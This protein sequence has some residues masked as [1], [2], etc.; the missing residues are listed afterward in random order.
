MDAEKWISTEYNDQKMMSRD[1]L[2]NRLVEE[3]RNVEE[4]LQSPG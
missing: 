3:R 4:R 2:R 1:H